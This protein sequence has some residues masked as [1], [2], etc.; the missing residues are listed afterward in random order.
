MWVGYTYIY[1]YIY[2]YFFF[3]SINKLKDFLDKNW[4]KL[5][6]IFSRNKFVKYSFENKFATFEKLL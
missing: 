3:F 4:D 5:F 2:I 6:E 1:I